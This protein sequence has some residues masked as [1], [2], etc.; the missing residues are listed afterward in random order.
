MKRSLVIA[1]VALAAS[2][3]GSPAYAQGSSVDQH[4]ACMAGRIGAGVA[5]PCQDGSAIYFNPA[6]LALQP[7][8]IGAGVTWIRRAN[9]FFYD[10]DIAPSVD[11]EA[12]TPVPY[13]FVSL[14]LGQRLAAGVGVFAPYGLGIDWDPT[15]FEGRYVGYDNALR[16]VYIQ[17]TVAFQLV[18]ERVTL[19]A[20]VD[21]VRG[22][23]EINQRADLATVP[24]TGTPFTFANFGIPFG[25][26]FADARLE[27]EGTG[28]TG[29]VGALVRLSDRFSIGAR[30]L[31]SAKIDFDE[32]TARFDPVNT[33]LVLGPSNPFRVP[34][35]TAVDRLVAGQFL[36]DSALGDQGVTTSLTFPAQAV[37]GVSFQLL[38]RLLLLAD[39]QWTGWSEFDQLDVD[40]ANARARDFVLPLDY[41]DTNTFRLGAEFSAANALMLRAGFRYNDAATPI[42]TPLLPENERNYYTAGLG[43]RFGN[44]LGIDAMYQ[45]VDQA[46]RRGRVRPLAP[47]EPSPGTEVG[48][49]TADAHV[50]GLTLSYRFG[51]TGMQPVGN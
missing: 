17:P 28:V 37:V 32:G 34:G 25:T 33:Q 12:T 46:D 39:Y 8:V 50:F 18:P 42:A 47:N 26:D 31:H 49:Y 43:Y 4:S 44:G 41:D 21:I 3:S 45:F 1:S 11:R 23:I 35:G 51:R 5:N 10:R 29:H 15:R 13:G 27:A 16:G 19:G 20:G 6:A 24:V 38:P 30:Y 9:E 22:S 7:S 36:P 14:R 48:L 2:V 40:F